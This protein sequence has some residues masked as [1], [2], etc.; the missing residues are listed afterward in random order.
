MISLIAI[1]VG[2]TLAILL[3]VLLV[4]DAPNTRGKSPD[5]IAIPGGLLVI[6]VILSFV[7]ALLGLVWDF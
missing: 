3:A 4:I 2:I 5:W 6:G 7:L 1:K